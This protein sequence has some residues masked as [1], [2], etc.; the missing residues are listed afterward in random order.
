[1]KT[2]TIITLSDLATTGIIPEV[3]NM[4]ENGGTP[5]LSIPVAA[6]AYFEVTDYD[7]AAGGQQ[8]T[9]RLQQTNDGVTW[10]TIGALQVAGVGEGVSLMVSPQIYWK[11]D[12]NAGPA[13][14][15]RIEI[16]TPDGPTPVAGNIS[17]NRVS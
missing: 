2:P 8:G 13:V 10:F 12:G 6:G 1:M 3:L 17:G 14:A 9:F 7:V 11:I 5:G 16:T 4:R 15:F